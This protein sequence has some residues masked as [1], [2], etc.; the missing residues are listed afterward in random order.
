MADIVVTAANVLK[1][2]NAQTTSGTAGEAI[3][4][5]ELVYIDG[6]DSN[7]IKLADADASEAASTL[8]GIALHATASGQ[9][10]L[11]ATKGDVNPG[12]T[13]VVGEIYVASGTAGG[14]APEGDLATNDW[15]VVFGYGTTTSIID[16]DI[17]VVGKQI[18]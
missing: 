2:A 10:I 9:P 5:G 17:K 4:A 1:G 6:T 16:V 18:P 15:L 7:K 3:T 12:G 14:I 11:Y 8:V 13:V